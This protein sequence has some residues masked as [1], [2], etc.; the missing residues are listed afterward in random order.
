MDSFVQK[1]G[2]FGCFFRQKKAERDYG[3]S[4]P[5]TVVLGRLDFG[6]ESSGMVV[7][8]CLLVVEVGKF[9]VDGKTVPGK[10]DLVDLRKEVAVEQNWAVI[11][12]VVLKTVDFFGPRIEVW[13]LETVGFAEEIS[14]VLEGVG[15]EGETGTVVERGLVEAVLVGA[16][17]HVVVG[18]FD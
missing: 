5:E 7:V 10:R 8:D 1:I 2:Y 15:E 13:C 11:H 18:I 16:A 3:R 6:S 17:G 9:V 14:Q 12:G 4:G